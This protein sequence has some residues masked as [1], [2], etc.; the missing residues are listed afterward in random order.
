[1]AVPKRPQRQLGGLTPLSDRLLERLIDWCDGPTLLR[2]GGTCRLAYELQDDVSIWKDLCL[3]R[4]KDGGLV[5]GKEARFVF[6]KS[7]KHTYFRPAS[8]PT[9][10]ER[11]RLKRQLSVQGDGWHRTRKSKRV[12][13]YNNSVDPS[14]FPLRGE[15]IPRVSAAIEPSEFFERFDK[16]NRPVILT[17]AADAWGWK[18]W[19]KK[20]L[21]RRHARTVFKTNGTTANDKTLRMTFEQ[22]VEYCDWAWG[23]GDKPMYIFD[24]KFEQRAEDLLDDFSIPPFFAGQDLFDEMTQEDRPDYKWLLI[25]PLGSG[26]PFH[27]DPHK[28]HAW[29]MVTEGRKRIAM[30]PPSVVPPGVDRKLIHSEY[31]AAPDTLEW[32]ID[33]YPRLPVD[34]LPMEAIV[35]PGE[36]L[37]IPSGWWHSVLNAAP[38]TIAVTQNVCTAGNFPRVWRDLQKRGPETL[39]RKFRTACLPKYR[40]LFDEYEEP[41]QESVSC[42]TYSSS[43]SDSSSTS[44]SETA[45]S[46]STSDS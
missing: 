5:E 45:S 6:K 39:K 30:Y 36:L 38:F 33:Y 44:T 4:I 14:S 31:Y 2:F 1:M 41:P 9:E 3:R 23:T 27:T 22:Y 16:G 17:G 12:R 43:D 18:Q 46:T 25:G 34:D 40:R 26:A 10:Q 35:E 11:S 29:N 20:S 42:S 37:F 28:T 8:V 32:F 19:T 13:W 7:W 24:N 21:L 15:A